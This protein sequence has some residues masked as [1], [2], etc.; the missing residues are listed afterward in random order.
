LSGHQSEKR[1]SLELLLI[2]FALSVALLYL[3]LNSPTVIGAQGERRVS[4]TLGRK[5]DDQDY[6]LLDDLTLPT[7]QGTTQVDHI[8][9]SRFGVFV[10]ETKNMSGWIFGGKSQARWTQV[11]RR[12]KSQFQNPLR[13]NYHHV[14][15]VQELLGIRLDQM[16]NLVA[17]VGSAEPKTEMPPNVFWNRRDLSNFIASRKTVRFT[18]SEVR[19]FAHKL[20]S[21]AL[22]A[23]KETRRA[24]VHHIREKATRKETDLTKCPR[25]GSKMIERTNHKTGQT[26]FGCSRYPKCRGTRQVK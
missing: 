2:L 16:E 5:L 8:V 13:Q 4:S 9:L 20:R 26:F 12:H 23:T 7:S 15:V 17:F 22:E 11:M 25:C 19:D 14:K 1:K 24:H 18:D 10:V 6:I 3:Y 21:S